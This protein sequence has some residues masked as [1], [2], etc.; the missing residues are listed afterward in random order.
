MSK[1][2]LKSVGVGSL[3]VNES[4]N[5]T[6]THS[7][8]LEHSRMIQRERKKR[9]GNRSKM[10]I[11]K[12]YQ[13]SDE[14]QKVFERSPSPAPRFMKEEVAVIKQIEVQRD[15]AQMAQA[16]ERIELKQDDAPEPV[17]LRA[18][19]VSPSQRQIL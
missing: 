19:M 5:L 9:L 13:T 1:V 17:D 14:E 3:N 4:Q 15:G 10:L 2:S 7:K 11:Q 18:L 6:S 8:K 16:F 12:E